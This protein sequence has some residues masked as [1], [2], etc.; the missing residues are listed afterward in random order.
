MGI[1]INPHFYFS[2]FRHLWGKPGEE[3]N[4]F[5]FILEVRGGFHVKLHGTC[6]LGREHLAMVVVKASN[7]DLWSK[8]EADRGLHEKKVG[9]VG[10]KRGIETWKRGKGKWGFREFRSKK[11]EGGGGHLKIRK[12]KS[13]NRTWRST[14]KYHFHT[15]F[16][17]I[18]FVT[19]FFMLF[20]WFWSLFDLFGMDT[21][22]HCSSLM[23]WKWLILQ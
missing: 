12:K 6:G 19:L 10:W 22:L 13:E 23:F 8:Q 2:F 14:F 1:F 4:I 15:D 7:D 20:G 17:F 3:P 5:I 18:F 16:L 21:M 11:K 9:W